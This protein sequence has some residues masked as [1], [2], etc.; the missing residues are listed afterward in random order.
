MHGRDAVTKDAEST[1]ALLLGLDD[2]DE[3]NAVFFEMNKHRVV[4]KLEKIARGEELS[5]DD[6]RTEESV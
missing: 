4:K 5:G 3:V 2:P 1:G 6:Y